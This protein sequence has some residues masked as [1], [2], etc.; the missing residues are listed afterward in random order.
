MSVPSLENA[1]FL[2]GKNHLAAAPNQL[3]LLA[4]FLGLSVATRLIAWICMKY[5]SPDVKQQIVNHNSTLERDY[6]GM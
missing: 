3:Q 1:S 2:I 5:L 4:L 6:N